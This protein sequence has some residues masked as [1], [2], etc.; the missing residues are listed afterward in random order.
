MGYTNSDL[1]LIMLLALPATLLLSF[2]VFLI[3]TFLPLLLSGTERTHFLCDLEE[4]EYR[5]FKEFSDCAYFHE[6]GFRVRAW[7][8]HLLYGQRKFPQPARKEK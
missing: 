5:K 6:R 3:M 8:Y 2:L 1:W 4:Y 7:T